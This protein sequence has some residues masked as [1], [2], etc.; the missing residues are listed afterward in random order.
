M[1]KFW[2]AGDIGGAGCY[3]RKPVLFSERRERSGGG[4]GGV[5]PLPALSVRKS[6]LRGLGGRDRVVH[7]AQLLS[8]G[9]GVVV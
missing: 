5:A 4:G 3:P 1:P 7:S 9:G 2:L 8:G 6:Q